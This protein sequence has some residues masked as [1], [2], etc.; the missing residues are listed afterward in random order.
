MFDESLVNDTLKILE[1]EQTQLD[2]CYDINTDATVPSTIEKTS[3]T[4]NPDGSWSTVTYEEESN[5]ADT[6]INDILRQEIVD[7]AVTLQQF[8]KVVDDQIISINAEIDIKKQ[9]I[10]TLSTEASTG[11]CWP[12]IAYS[13][14]GSISGGVRTGI[15]S[16]YGGNVNMKND[17]E[18]IRIYPNMSGPNANF[19]VDNP[20][21][22]DTVYQL[23]EAYSGY[24]YKNLQDPIFYK[25]KDGTL[26]GL[27]TD[28]SGSDLGV[29]KFDISKIL[30][31]HG[32]RIVSISPNFKWYFGPELPTT[33]ARCVEISDQI[34]SI[35]NEIIGLRNERDSLRTDLNT[36]KKNKSDKELSSWGVNRMYSVVDS[37]STSN[38]SAIAAVNKFSAN[39]TGVSEQLILHLDVSNADSYTGIGTNWY[40]LSGTGN[41][42]VLY[43]GGSPASY[44]YSDGGF[45]TFNGT[46]N[47]ADTAF[48]GSDILGTG[49]WT[50][51]TWFRING[52]PTRTFNSVV[53][54]AGTIM[55]ISGII[56]GITTTNIAVG[57]YL[58]PISGI[59][60]SDTVVTQIG[61]GSVYISPSSSNTGTI[62]TSLTF[63][64]YTQ[65][66]N[67]IVDTNPTG[68]SSNMLSVTYGQSGD[69][70]GLEANKLVYSSKPSAGSYTHLVGSAV[71][72]GFWYHGV[73]VRNGT[74][75]TKLYSNGQLVNTFNGDV[76]TEGEGFVRIA[77]WTDSTSYSNISVSVVKIYNKAYTDDE[78]LQKFIDSKSRY[79]LIG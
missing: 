45:L 74:T 44:E 13:T 70:S 69:F 35:Y 67:T 40:D 48:K 59:I 24:G 8:C 17:I 6:N 50:I 76:P 32:A 58:N 14:V 12:G 53:S 55:P 63:G 73:V 33:A 22:P 18:N 42:A 68:T 65:Y 25:N 5:L 49:D 9:Q 27:S 16:Y 79:G 71:T 62:S 21:E 3:V 20:F 31:D 37:R 38:S 30:T 54:V 10:I 57:Q 11:N 34:D 39:M 52:S 19:N 7:K 75:N 28:G 41:N 46:N 66:A 4:Q 2:G 78:V 29:G 23:T 51:E 36:I 61:I 56:T 64:N 1:D 77:A 43:P 60:K 47:Y 15:A 72:S 26:T